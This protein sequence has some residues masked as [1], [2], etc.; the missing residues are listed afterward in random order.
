MASTET[1]LRMVGKSVC[2]CRALQF[3]LFRSVIHLHPHAD[4]LTQIIVF[5]F[6]FFSVLNTNWKVTAFSVCLLVT[7]VFH[8]CNAGSGKLSLLNFSK[9]LR[10]NDDAVKMFIFYIQWWPGSFWLVT[11]FKI[12][13]SF[14]WGKSCPF[15][16]VNS[17]VSQQLFS[18]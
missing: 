17:G 1:V 14:S 10:K 16:F 4:N 11:V 15:C 6:A 9:N 13:K 3:I 12:C 5:G 7:Q 18:I 2:Q 8:H